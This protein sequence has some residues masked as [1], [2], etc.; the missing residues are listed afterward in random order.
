MPLAHPPVHPPEVV[1]AGECLSRLDVLPASAALVVDS[2]SEPLSSRQ[3]AI[4]E[5]ECR[6]TQLAPPPALASAAYSATGVSM[7]TL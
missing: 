3:D 1:D 2:T 4:S 7:G 5:K 6:L